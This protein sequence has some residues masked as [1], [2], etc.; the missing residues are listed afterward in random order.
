[1]FT[2]RETGFLATATWKG[3]RIATRPVPSFPGGLPTADPVRILG[4]IPASGV[5]TVD[6]Q[7]PT[8]DPAVLEENWFFQVWRNSP[9]DGRTLG[10]FA[11]VTILDSSY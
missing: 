10:G 11:V 8:L 5:L 6:L 3:A 9:I 1:M 4:T 2:S 7:I